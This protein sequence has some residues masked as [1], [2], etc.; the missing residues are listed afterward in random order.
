[1][2][3]SEFAFLFQ[4]SCVRR[5]GVCFDDADKERFPVTVT[6]TVVVNSGQTLSGQTEAFSRERQACEGF[7]LRTG[8]VGDEAFLPGSRQREPWVSRVPQRRS[9][10]SDLRV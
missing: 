2:L 3:G 10:E 4:C 9:A 6:A 7:H 1:M 8:S 5:C